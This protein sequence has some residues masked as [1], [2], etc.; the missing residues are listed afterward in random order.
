MRVG[1]DLKLCWLPL[2]L[3]RLIDQVFVVED[4]IPRLAD[5]VLDQLLLVKYK[6]LH[7]GAIMDRLPGYAVPAIALN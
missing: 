3:D 5:S 4:P 7:F 1:A 6:H 2:V